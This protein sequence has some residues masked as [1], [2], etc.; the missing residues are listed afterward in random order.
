MTIALNALTFSV[1]Q[2]CFMFEGN[3]RIN[4]FYENLKSYLNFQFFSSAATVEE[5]FNS[6]DP[7]NPQTLI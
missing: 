1:V 7:M 4:Q 2:Y 5:L 3:L 6:H